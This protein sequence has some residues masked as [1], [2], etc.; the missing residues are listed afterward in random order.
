MSLVRLSIISS[1][2][3]LQGE[4]GGASYRSKI[5]AQRSASAVGRASGF[6]FHHFAAALVQVGALAAA[7]EQIP[8]DGDALDQCVQLGD[9][10]TGDALPA[11]GWTAMIVEQSA[12]LIERQAAVLGA[13]ENGQAS[14]DVGT[15]SPLAARTKRLRQ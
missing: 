5:D 7:L 10:D 11:F 3:I 2:N 13:A 6:C 14:E 1:L 4:D 12:D 15:I 9:L 8:H